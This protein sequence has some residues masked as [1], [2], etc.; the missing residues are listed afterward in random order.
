M[1]RLDRSKRALNT[2]TRRDK[3]SRAA[4]ILTSLGLV[5]GRTLDYGCGFGFDAGHFGWDAY[6]PYYH[7]QEPEGPYDTVL[8]TLVLNVLS[9]NVRARALA[10]IEELLTE[11]GH[12]YLAV[13]RNI[14]FTGKMGI[15]HS[16]QNYVVLTLP[17]VYADDKLE[18][19]NLTRGS[20]FEDKTKEYMSRRDKLRER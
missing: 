12:A 10:R 11:D 17:S 9:R 7:P 20:R 8:C 15:H 5:K 2:A 19:Y 1:P 16:L 4:E 3:P 18:I 6:D 14:P 13:P